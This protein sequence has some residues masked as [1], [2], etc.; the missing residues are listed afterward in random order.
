MDKEVTVSYDFEH[1]LSNL[2]GKNRYHGFVGTHKVA[3]WKGE[4]T[5]VVRAIQRTVKINVDTDDFHRRDIV[6]CCE[7]TIPSL[8]AAQT[9]NEV[10]TV[11][12]E[13][14]IKTIF[15]LLGHLPDNWD[16]KSISNPK[17]WRLDTFRKLA[18][19]RTPEQRANLVLSLT[20]RYGYSDRLPKWRDL[21]LK[22]H[23]EFKGDPVKFLEWFK[24]NYRDVYDEIV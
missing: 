13:F 6:D 8:K 5:K 3:R 17:L 1:L 11:M 4:L 22:R 2:F 9:S 15:M 10:N 14:A 7:R 23:T 21:L 20:D 19:I 16:K 18:Y 24:Q 12:I